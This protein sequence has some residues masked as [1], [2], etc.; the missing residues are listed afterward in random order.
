MKNVKKALR[1]HHAQEYCHVTTFNQQMNLH[2]SRYEHY[3]TKPPRLLGTLHAVPWAKNS[4]WVR[5]WV[6]RVLVAVPWL[7]RLGPDLSPR[8]P[9]FTPGSIHV[10]F[11]V[12]KVALGQVF[13]RRSLTPSIKYKKSVAFILWELAACMTGGYC[14]ATMGTPA[15]ACW[16][17]LGKNKLR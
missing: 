9:G 11:V 8:S 14:C 15:S 16:N 4:L 5:P 17:M 10:G 7:W 2:K 3:A 6:C 1:Y 13:L 12:D